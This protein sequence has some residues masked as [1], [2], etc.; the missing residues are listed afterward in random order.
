MKDV[1]DSL[2]PYREPLSKEAINLLPMVGYDGP[3]YLVQ[4]ED[5]L[6]PALDRLRGETVLGFDTEMRPS[7][8]RGKEVYP[9]SLLQLSGEHCVV[10]I[11][12]NKVPL[13]EALTTILCDPLVLKVGVAIGDDMRFLRRKAE[14]SPAGLVDLGL[15]ARSHNIK[16]Q[17]LRSLAANF[18]HVRISKTAQCSNWDAAE[19]S[20]LQIRYAATDAWIG[21]QIYL[22]M[23]DVS[24]MRF[25]GGV[26]PEPLSK[27]RRR[28]RRGMS[29]RG[30]S[31]S[32]ST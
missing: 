3:V 31:G 22:K 21:R 19:L 16:T 27:K 1:M 11:R 10:L 7:F 9:T 32:V 26:M 20:P 24:G 14:F 25:Q 6:C 17:G 28:A 13:T 2:D 29:T 18:L 15:T 12:L 23:S 8:V 5:E 30:E 4:R